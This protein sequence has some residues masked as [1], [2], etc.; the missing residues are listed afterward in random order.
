MPHH[1]NGVPEY[2]STC[3]S[4]RIR[5]RGTRFGIYATSTIHVIAWYEV[6]K[7]ADYHQNDRARLEQE[8]QECPLVVMC[9]RVSER[10]LECACVHAMCMRVCVCVHACI[11]THI[12]AC[13][14]A[15]VHVRVLV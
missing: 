11:C 2:V 10:A 4:A 9:A 7:I 8:V 14:S 5:A 1:A 3:E 12:R 13:G 15:C 6:Q